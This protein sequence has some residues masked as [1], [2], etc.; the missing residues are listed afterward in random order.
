MKIRNKIQ[1]INLIDEFGYAPKDIECT[2]VVGSSLK[3]IQFDITDKSTGKSKLYPIERLT[4]LHFE[5]WKEPE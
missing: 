1:S 5:E 4:M 2:V 3:N